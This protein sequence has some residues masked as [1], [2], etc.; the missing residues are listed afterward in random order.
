VVLY[1]PLSRSREEYVRIPVS[2]PSQVTDGAGTSVPS[3]TLNNTLPGID[4]SSDYSVAFIATLPAVG[5][6]TYFIT[7]AANVEDAMPQ[8]LDTTDGD[9]VVSNGVFTMTISASTGRILSV[10]QVATG[11]LISF[12]QVWVYSLWRSS[13]VF[14]CV[15]QASLLYPRNGI[16]GTVART[17]S[18]RLQVWKFQSHILLWATR[19][20]QVWPSCFRTKDTLVCPHGFV[21]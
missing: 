7:P 5:Y 21:S 15:F 1:N 8:H 19:S 10:E 14:S 17:R 4:G 3:T 20:R 9:T 6:A 12:T 18:T 2:G 11:D 13:T 16:G